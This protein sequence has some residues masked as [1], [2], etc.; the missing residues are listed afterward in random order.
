MVRAVH[1]GLFMKIFSY[2]WLCI[3]LILALALPVSAQSIGQVP[4]PHIRVGL[5]KPT[6]FVQFRSEEADYDIYDGETK[7]G[8]LPVNRLGVLKYENGEYIFK[9][10]GLELRS[11]VYFRLEPVDNPHAVFALVNWQRSVKSYP[12]DNFNEYR[13]ALEY[14]L[15]QSGET[16]YAIN[17][18]LFEDY[19]AGVYEASNGAPLEYLKALMTAARTYAFYVQQHTTKHDKRN[20]DVVAT[21]GDQLYVG[22]V[23]EA[24]APRIKEAAGATRGFFAT[25]QN[26][27]II[28]PYFSRSNG[29]TKSWKQ[30][31][32]GKGKPWL[33]SVAADYD[34]GWSQFGHGV[35][36]SQRDAFVR[37]KHEGL[38]W[39]ALLQ[40]YYTGVEIAKLYE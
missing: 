28:T 27:V 25:Y 19:V 4:E 8:T 34:A 9:G 14:R 26:D 35:G 11:A 16:M 24:V 3:A 7:V 23:L 40:Y 10:A 32:G 33:I 15:T 21:T 13:G 20:F 6:N 30:V 2:H 39:Q 22:A 12:Y 36:M 37:A 5:W 38:D 17:D 18:V 29:K 1:Y 31:W